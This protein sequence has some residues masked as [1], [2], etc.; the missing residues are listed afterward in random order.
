M[1]YKAQSGNRRRDVSGIAG[2][3]FE[4][5]AAEMTFCLH[6][7]DQVRGY[8]NLRDT[9]QFIALAVEKPAKKGEL[10]I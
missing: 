3:A 9:L 2:A 8:L 5:A 1:V 7:P 10:R 4:I 6:M